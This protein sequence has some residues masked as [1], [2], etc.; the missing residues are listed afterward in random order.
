LAAIY[1][2]NGKL[3]VK[4][5]NTVKNM[6]CS[7]NHAEI[8]AIKEAQQIFK[9]YNLS[10][11]DLSLYITS[12]PCMM[13]I[14]AIMWSGLK[15][16]YYGVPSKKVEEITGFDEGFKQDWLEEF[17]KRG[18]KVCGNI[19]AEAGEKALKKYIDEGNDIYKPAR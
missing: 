14:G 5:A 12:E 7:N 16:V 17:K 8:N 1:D 9:T 3:I 10:G 2:K 6:L 15:S 13:C 18:I 4:C 11:L 19:A